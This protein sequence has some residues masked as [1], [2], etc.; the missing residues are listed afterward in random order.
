MHTSNKRLFEDFLDDNID[1]VTQEDVLQTSSTLEIRFNWD[2]SRQKLH[3]LKQFDYNR[4]LTS[5]IRQTERLLLFDIHAAGH[6]EI[7]VQTEHAEPEHFITAEED[8]LKQIKRLDYAI[9][10]D[11]INQRTRFNVTISLKFEVTRLRT[12]SF[13]RFYR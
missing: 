9:P 5:I 4:F 11:E 12:C 3:Q 6:P 10:E 8:I 7:W 2:Y 1:I 13:E